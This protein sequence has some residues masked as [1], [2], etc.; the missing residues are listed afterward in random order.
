MALFVFFA[1]AAPARLIAFRLHGWQM[2]PIQ[3][4]PDSFLLLE[5]RSLVDLARLFGLESGYK[6]NHAGLVSSLSLLGGKNCQSEPGRALHTFSQGS[7]I[8]QTPL[9]R[10]VSR[11]Q[12][13]NVLAYIGG[14]TRSH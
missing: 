3:I 14:V 10:V 13:V 4:K 6:F 8:A 7:A 5:A 12:I 1:A 2:L 11:H 9:S